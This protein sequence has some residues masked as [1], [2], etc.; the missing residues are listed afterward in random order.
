MPD[1][2]EELLQLWQ[3]GMTLAPELIEE[4]LSLA[5]AGT[6]MAL[7]PVMD[8]GVS[9]VQQFFSN[10]FDIQK[11]YRRATEQGC[12][13]EVIALRVQHMELW[14]RMFW[15]AKNGR[16]SVFSAGDRRTFGMIIGACVE[17]GLPEDLATDLR[18]FNDI[19]ID[20]V[21]KYV[22]GDIAY[23]DLA[24]AASDHPRL[25]SRVVEFVRSKIA[26]PA[27]VE[28]FERGRGSVILV[29]TPSRR[30]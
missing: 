16:G 23:D 21:H 29:R 25:N 27:T 3:T 7:P 1:R 24:T 13:I 18:C 15:V 8:I 26:W 6:F 11:R 14:L 4:L 12:F 2:F 22:L 19:R 5:P 30:A 10:T 20:A 9:N 17:V 28:D